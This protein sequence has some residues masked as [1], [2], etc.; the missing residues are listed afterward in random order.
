MIN[1]LATIDETTIDRVRRMRGLALDALARM[2][3]PDK[4]AFVYRLRQDG[5]N[6]RPEG[7]SARYTAIVLIGLAGE[8][9]SSVRAALHGDAIADVC[10]RL[11]EQAVD[12]TPGNLGDV[13]LTYWAAR[14]LDHQDASRALTRLE[15]MMREAR[16]H[17]TVE[18]AWAVSALCQTV[19]QDRA[20]E[21]RDEALRRLLTAYR[22]EARLFAH[23]TGDDGSGLRGHVSC[24]ADLV[25]PI[26]A[27]ARYHA[28]L[29]RSALL[30]V[31]NRCAG[32][33]CELLGPDGQWWWHYDS[34]TGRVLEQ[35]P[36]Y[37]VH[38]DA[39]APMA[40]FDLADAGGDDHSDAIQR[41]W[42]W[43]E[44]SPELAGG[45]LIDEPAGLIWRKVARGDPKKL[46][47]KMQ[48]AASRMH[49]AARMPGVNVVFPAGKIDDECRPYH[50]GWLL[51]AWPEKRLRDLV[52]PDEP[53]AGRPCH[54]RKGD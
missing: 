32:R 4:Q 48:A 23:W 37:S 28:K 24:F 22:A 2:Y 30:H 18:I 20:A 6:A 13:A 12:A 51:Y 11:I 29:N 40:L 15:Q 33:K 54:P 25:Y 1:T 7:E 47:R 19:E 43:L 49:P 14:A 38:Q 3:L 46:V 21:L 8:P 34:R 42:E 45:S 10:Q 53:R 17:E 16:M 41:G 26:Q 35:Y 27:L 44:Q 9:A 52:N 36:V 50:L 39:M 5:R 31:A